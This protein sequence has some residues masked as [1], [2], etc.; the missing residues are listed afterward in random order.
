MGSHVMV[1]QGSETTFCIK[2]RSAGSQKQQRQGQ[3]D[4]AFFYCV[5]IDH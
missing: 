4:P 1:L 5:L 2:G 3:I